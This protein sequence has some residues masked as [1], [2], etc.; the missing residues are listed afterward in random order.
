MTHEER[1]ERIEA[2]MER[3]A[4]G[5]E[6]LRGGQK[7]LQ[8]AHIELEAAQLNQAKAHTKLVAVVEDLGERIVNLAILVDRLIAKDLGANGKK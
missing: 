7:I 8:D 3:F 5:M 1:F 6:D 4:S 2:M